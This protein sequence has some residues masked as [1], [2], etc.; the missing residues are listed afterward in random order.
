MFFV[1]DPYGDVEVLVSYDRMYLEE[2]PMLWMDAVTY[3][4]LFLTI[5]IPPEIFKISRFKI[6]MLD[7]K[8]ESNAIEFLWLY[9]CRY[10]DIW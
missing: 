6:I 8:R 1:V 9:N 2:K 7:Q 5:S 3:I 4:T 10:C